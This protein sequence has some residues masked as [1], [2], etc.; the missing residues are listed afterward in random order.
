M[1]ISKSVSLNIGR[2]QIVTGI[3]ATTIAVWGASHVLA[4]SR[5]RVATP[6]QTEGPFYPLDW[7]GDT[8]NDL[9]R[10]RGVRG[11]ALGTIAHVM[12]RVSDFSGAPM[13]GAMVEIWQCDQNGRYHHLRDRGQQRRD[14]GFQGHGR[15]ISDA[16]GY[17]HF[18]TIRPMSYPGRTPHIHFAVVA[19]NGRRL[20]TQMYIEGES[21]NA[22]DPL[23][24]SIRDRRQRASVIVP[25]EPA[26]RVELVAL[27]G[28]FDIVF[29][30]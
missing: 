25:L 30:E 23:L 11:Q 16:R 28:T 9:V 1:L 13:A 3:A 18:R 27:A 10:V 15:T 2:R 24:N 22:G 8:D 6:R 5:N 14:D 26:E 4:L 7:S 29:A 17:Y 12:G 20:V 21:A 19:P